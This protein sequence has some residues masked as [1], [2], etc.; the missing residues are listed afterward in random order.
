M[1]GTPVGFSKL[2]L[3]NDNVI[4]NENQKDTVVNKQDQL[5]QACVQLLL[6]IAENTKVEE[7]MRTRNISSML[8]KLLES[9]SMGLLTTCIKFLKKLSV[10]RENKDDMVDSNVIEKLCKIFSIGNKDLILL[11]L[12]LMYN[13]SFD[14]E[15]RER[16]VMNGLLTKLVSYLGTQIFQFCFFF[17]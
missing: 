10:F 5:L 7:K 14:A 9:N 8:I 17:F 13:L 12:K 3:L 16:I 1:P 15:I 11:T 2:D 6:N 4:S